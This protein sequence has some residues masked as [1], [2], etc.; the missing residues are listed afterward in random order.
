MRQ[1]E[2]S[3]YE[4]VKRN[5]FTGEISAREVI[6]G[7]SRAV[8]FCQNQ[9]ATLSQEEKEKEIRW[10]IKKTTQGPSTIKRHRRVGP[11][12]RH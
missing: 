7:Y 11:P 3:C 5:W 2:T 4:V 12:K 10:Y 8:R 9:K 1:S 6:R